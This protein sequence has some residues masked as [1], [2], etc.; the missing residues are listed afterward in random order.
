MSYVPKVLARAATLDSNPAGVAAEMRVAAELCRFGFHVAR[1]YWTEDEI[2][3]L[4]AYE[5]S[6]TVVF[7]PIQVKCV[8]FVTATRKCRVPT[9]FIQGLKKRYIEN[10]KW[11]SLVLYNP[12]E[13]WFW[14]IDGAINICKAYDA[15]K[16]WHKHI[17]Y[18]QIADDA[19]VRIGL[20]KKGR[21]NFDA[22]WKCPAKAGT[23]WDQR[24]A[25]IAKQIAENRDRVAEIKA[26]MN[27]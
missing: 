15:Q 6:G 24:L 23:F 11:L 8:Q 5:I 20:T 16:A 26:A 1:P 7:V 14:F 12:H 18:N 17:A 21:D 4:V 22:L 19:D 3:L 2:D 9:C 10:N 25:R 27:W 13:D